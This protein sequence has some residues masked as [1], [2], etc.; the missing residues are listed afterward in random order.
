M[1]GKLAPSHR[2]P[3]SNPSVFHQHPSPGYIARTK[4]YPPTTLGPPHSQNRNYFGT[5]ESPNTFLFWQSNCVKLFG[6][7]SSMVLASRQAHS[8]WYECLQTLLLRCPRDSRPF[9]VPMPYS[10]TGMVLVLILSARVPS[11]FSTAVHT[12]CLFRLPPH[13]CCS[14]RLPSTHAHDQTP[15]MV[16]S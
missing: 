4:H 14:Q 8:L 1:A 11:R 6:F 16:T 9:V 15:V 10:H 13:C 3:C 7:I 5:V 12:G 2:H